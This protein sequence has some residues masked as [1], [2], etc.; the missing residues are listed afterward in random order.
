MLVGP[1]RAW[2]VAEARGNRAREKFRKHFAGGDSLC[3]I[4]LYIGAVLCVRIT[5][6]SL[7]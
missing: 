4:G 2:A 7:L 3:N 1:P 5:R 6:R